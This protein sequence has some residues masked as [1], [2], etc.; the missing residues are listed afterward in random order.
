MKKKLL[1]GL[2]TLAA[3][4]TPIVAVVS[5]GDD[6]EQ[7]QEDFDKMAQDYIDNLH[8]EENDDKVDTPEQPK[9]DDTSNDDASGPQVVDHSNPTSEDG[10]QPDTTV[11]GEGNAQDGTQSPVVHQTLFE[12]TK[13][14]LLVE[15]PGYRVEQTRGQHFIKLTIGG[16]SSYV[17]SPD[18]NPLASFETNGATID[19]DAT[20]GVQTITNINPA[21]Q[22]SFTAEYDP[23]LSTNDDAF[24]VLEGAGQRWVVFT[25]SQELLAH[26]QITDF[27]YQ[28]STSTN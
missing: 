22:Q 26:Y 24:A 11:T 19:T 1:L 10:T 14:R 16:V 2:G 6:E 5:C 23:S 28:D 7:T 8:G 25:S 3:V 18:T 13:A 4:A 20:T 9:T 12:A 21:N 15:H 17:L 27:V